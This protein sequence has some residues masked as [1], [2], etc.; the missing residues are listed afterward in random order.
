M[1]GEFLPSGLKAAFHAIMGLFRPLLLTFVLLNSIVLA[2]PAQTPRIIFQLDWKP[3]VQYAGP[4]V[5]LSYHWYE[6]AGLNVEIR[7]N[8][9]KGYYL[10]RFSDTDLVVTCLDGRSLFTQ[11]AKGRKLKAF[12][13]MFQGSPVGFITKKNYGYDKL[14]D[15]VGRTIGIHRP[16]D[17]V[18]LDLLFKGGGVRNAQFRT[19][20]IGFRLDELKADEVAAAQGYVID[21]Y[22]RLNAEGIPAN[23]YLLSDYGYKDY[24]QLFIGT[25]SLLKEHPELVQKFLKVTLRGWR[26]AFADIPLTAKWI[27]KYYYPEGDLTYQVA[28]LREI[29]KLMTRE[30]GADHLGKMKRETWESLRKTIVERNLLK[31]PPAVD[32]VVTFD[33]SDKL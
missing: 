24:S 32:Q 30:S 16:E 9:F 6:K 1:G 14:E 5:A 33:Y 22:V 2:A 20:K 25:D 21:E 11:R 31:D 15:L 12:A 18:W 17:T 4:L 19:K 3:N 29:Q 23:C 26:E 7:P 13:T 8:A 28:S 10:D 27:Q